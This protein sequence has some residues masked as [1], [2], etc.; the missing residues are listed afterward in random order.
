M[1]IFFTFVPVFILMLPLI[2]IGYNI[3]AHLFAF[4]AAPIMSFIE[5]IFGEDIFEKAG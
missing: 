2:F 5:N 4:I 3:L 1:F